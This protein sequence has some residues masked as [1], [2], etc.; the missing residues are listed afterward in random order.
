MRGKISDVLL[1]WEEAGVEAKDS[2][3]W[4][5]SQLT[6]GRQSREKRNSLMF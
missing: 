2:E 5:I 4:I 6:F 1:S 3:I